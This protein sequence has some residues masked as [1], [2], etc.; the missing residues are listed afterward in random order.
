MIVPEQIVR[1]SLEKIFEFIKSDWDNASSEQE[2]YLYKVLSSPN[3]KLTDRYEFYTQA[4]ALFTD[5]PDGRR[6]LRTHLFFNAERQGSPTM[7]IMPSNDSSIPSGLGLNQGETM[8]ES[9]DSNQY[10]N[11]IMTRAYNSQMP[12]VFTSENPSEVLMM[13]YFVRQLLVPMFNH[14]EMMGLKNCTM[15]GAAINI[16]EHL[17]PK[18][19][20]AKQLTLSYYNELNSV[21]FYTLAEIN[22]LNFIQIIQDAFNNNTTITP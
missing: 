21:N 15:S 19:I 6:R 10:L 12:M 8:L 9:G 22:G 11:Q 2:S 3:L 17:V 18:G 20:F 14:F 4:K 1:D 7:H 16:E 5:Q 13:Y